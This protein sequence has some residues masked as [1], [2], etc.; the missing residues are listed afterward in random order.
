M[1]PGAHAEYLQRRTFANLDGLRC[2]SILAVLWYHVPRSDKLPG[3]LE[4]GFLGVDLFFV[5]S[6]FLITTL[7][8]REQDRHGRI[9]LT[10]FYMRRT[11]RIFPI[12]YL[13]LCGYWLWIANSAHAAAIGLPQ[14]FY[15]SLL[16]YATYTA[17]VVS[18]ELS[19]RHTW[20]LATEEQFYLLWPPLLAWLGVRK[21][22][23][24]LLGAMVVM[25]GISFGWFDALVASGWQPNPAFL[26]T[27]FAP[28]LLGV[29]LAIALHH[30]RPFRRAQRWLHRPWVGWL[31]VAL[32]GWCGSM[33]SNGDLQIGGE[34]VPFRGI[35]RLATHLSMVALLAHCV[36][37]ERTWLRPLLSAL[38]V[39]Y[40]GRISYGMYLLHAPVFLAW[41][42]GGYA[43]FGLSSP[44]LPFAPAL[45]L[46]GVA[47][48]LSVLAAAISFHGF[49]Q[50]FL[51][52]K[53]RFERR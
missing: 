52:L 35:W 19:W 5:I 28:I 29:M 11:L 7:L 31:L 37:Q 25:Q 12:Y 50:P 26:G 48:V 34:T 36:V 44:A 10:A 41:Y 32:V 38:P 24:V 45:L 33:P 53:Q 30:E 3:V 42:A 2:I 15:A 14:P 16:A 22:V 46:F 39:T 6:G 21:S 51:R 18:T 17:N 27:T 40:L 8:L 49:E 13:S 23:W 1:L 9:S 43:W 4:R 47:T 20:S